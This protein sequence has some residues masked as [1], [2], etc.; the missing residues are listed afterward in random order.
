MSYSLSLSL[1]LLFLLLF[2]FSFPRFFLSPP[3]F[4]FSLFSV[5]LFLVF[6]D[7]DSP[8]PPLPSLYLSLFPLPLPSFFM[9]DF[10]LYFFSSFSIFFSVIVLPLFSSVFDGRDSFLLK[11]SSPSRLSLILISFV[12]LFNFHTAHTH[13]HTNTH[14]H[15]SK[16][17]NKS[18]KWTCA[19]LSKG[20]SVFIRAHFCAFDCGRSYRGV[21]TP[22]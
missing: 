16:T 17:E 13:P 2:L 22:V 18:V 3:G 7:R 15:T 6:D 14:T 1:S 5:C 10:C 12:L 4:Y 9:L 11:W 8:H 20:P 19:N 21:C